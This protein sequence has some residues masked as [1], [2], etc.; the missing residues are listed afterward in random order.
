MSPPDEEGKP[1]QRKGWRERIWARRE[2]NRSRNP[3]PK[4]RP[5]RRRVTREWE[6]PKPSPVK[7]W[8]VKGIKRKTLELV[9]VASRDQHPTEFSAVLRAEKGII[10]E[11]MPLPG[12]VS[13]DRHAILNLHMLPVDMS[14]VGVVHSHPSPNNHWSDA[15]LQLFAYFGH[16]HIIVAYP[17][18][19]RSWAAYDHH[20]NVL[21]LEVVD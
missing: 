13:G 10:T 8:P 3:K 9:C 7:D 18:T 16:T 15:D 1:R 5:R 12:T 20:G 17:Y 21:S 14:V 19:E 11:I 6:E 4:P 2:Q